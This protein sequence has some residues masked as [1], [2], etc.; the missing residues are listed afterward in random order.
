MDHLNDE[1]LTKNKLDRGSIG[2]F[3][4]WFCI[5]MP[6]AT[7]GC[8]YWLIPTI[9]HYRAENWSKVLEHLCGTLFCSWVAYYISRYIIIYDQ[10]HTADLV[11]G[12]TKAQIA[13][14]KKASPNLTIISNPK[15]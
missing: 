15:R 3:I 10:L 13:E 4:K 8:G 9:D 6:I 5:C 11:V 2:A 12:L 14:L 7:I 1:K